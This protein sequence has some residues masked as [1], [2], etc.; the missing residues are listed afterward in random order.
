MW[1][2]LNDNLGDRLK[3]S[4]KKATN[5]VILVAPFITLGAFEELIDELRPSVS[6]RVITRWNVGDISAGVSDPRIWE[7]VS[8]RDRTNIYLLPTLHAKYYRF[9]SEILVG[10][11][12]ITGYALGLGDRSNIELLSK[13]RN[14]E[15]GRE[16]ESQL[17]RQA[18]EVDEDMYQ[19]ALEL[20]PDIP[21]DSRQQSSA[22]PSVQTPAESWLPRLR[23][24]EALWEVYSDTNDSL[25][26]TTIRNALDDLAMWDIPLNL[27][28]SSFNSHISINLLH[29][30]LIIE[31]DQLL[32]VPQRFGSVRDHIAAKFRSLG[33][34][35]K[36]DEC[37][38]TTIR[39][40]RLFWPNRYSYSVPNYSEIMVR[41]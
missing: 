8:K 22:F 16:F 19:T 7:S 34:D 9:D 28:E 35:R 18:V 25:T 5:S 3:A 26:Q 40:L 13:L 24:P 1:Q 11:A 4:V 30:P 33:V 29:M 15:A 20:I 21:V 10:S 31:I 14:V 23:H 12:N 41:K 27:T 37:W 39:W 2:S 17:L 6:L 32:V 36:P 38:Q